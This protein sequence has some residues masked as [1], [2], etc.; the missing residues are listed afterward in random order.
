M[1]FLVVLAFAM[2]ALTMSAR[3]T[4]EPGKLQPLM[5]QPD[6]VALQGDFSKPLPTGKGGPYQARQGTRWSTADGVLRGMSST[7]EYQ[8]SR[9][10]HK[11]TEPRIAFT[12]GGQEYVVDVTYRFMGGRPTAALPIMEFGH[13]CGRVNWANGSGAKLVCDEESVL[14][15]EAPDC[16][17]ELGKWYHALCE[18]KGDEIVVQFENGP[19]LYGKHASLAAKKDRPDFSIAGTDN[20]TVEIKSLTIWT[21]KAE[22]QASWSE[23]RAKLPAPKGT[24]LVKK[25]NKS[26]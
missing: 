8:A 14:L 3:A 7:P 22:P 23:T 26:E 19:T 24:A 16:K 2:L 13:H 10:D 11:G 5:V 9:K 1:S 21:A 15:A 20:G 25:K 4:D 18:V 12:A 6:K 17:V